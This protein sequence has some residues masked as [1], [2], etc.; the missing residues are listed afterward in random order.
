[1]ERTSFKINKLKLI[2]A[3]SASLIFVAIGSFL[4]NKG[5]TNT[6]FSPVL[7]Q[8]VGYASIVFF[9][10]T[11]TISA[12][13]IIKTGDVFYTDEDGLFDDSSF[14][15]V[16]HLSW[17]EIQDISLIKVGRQYFILVN[18]TNADA[19]LER[20]SKFKRI[21]VSATMK[22]YGSPVLISLNNFRDKPTD[23]FEKLEAAM[24][25]KG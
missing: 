24:K 16:G 15:S 8:V 20:Y 18:V 21:L 17:D 4:I 13:Q 9:S 19:V 10:L 2:G 6:K 22:R 7:T 1:M 5:G 12:L 3:I 23:V 14:V 11:G 25:Q